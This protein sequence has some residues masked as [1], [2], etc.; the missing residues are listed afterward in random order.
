MASNHSIAVRAG[1]AEEGVDAMPQQPIGN[2][3][4]T[5]HT[6]HGGFAPLHLRK[7]VGIGR[8]VRQESQSPHQSEHGE[9]RMQLPG[10]PRPNPEDGKWT[11]TKIAI[12]AAT[13]VVILALLLLDLER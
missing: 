4:R 9:E 11:F 8:Q 13:A 5:R 2:G 3:L 10:G 1:Q 7:E 6:R 12:V